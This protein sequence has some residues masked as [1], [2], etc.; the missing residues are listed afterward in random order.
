MPQGFDSSIPPVA[1]ATSK[2]LA[3]IRFHGRD[4]EIWEKKATTAAERFRYDYREKELEE[5]V[6]R[7]G[8]LAGQASETH[9]V[10]NNC[11]EN[12]A[13]KNARQLADLME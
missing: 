1:A 2:D 5:W 11:Y 4:P 13:V 9:V 10:M 12:Y 6:P 7:I 3:M 8:E